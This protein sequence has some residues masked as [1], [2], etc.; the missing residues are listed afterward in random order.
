M[1][2]RK[3]AAE[4]LREVPEGTPADYARSRRLG[5][6]ILHVKG[7]EVILS[8][9]QRRPSL[10]ESAKE[11]VGRLVRPGKPKRSDYDRFMLRFHDYLKASAE[12]QTGPRRTRWR[13]CFISRS[14]FGQSSES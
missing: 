10:W 14:I 9:D 12:F 1:A 2:A 8:P 5:Y 11:C 13:A 6:K 7:R 4:V 3:I